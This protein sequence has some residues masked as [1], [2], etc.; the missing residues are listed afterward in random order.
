MTDLAQQARQTLTLMDLTSLN[1]SDTDAVITQLCDAART[2][3]GSPAAVC[4]YPAFI[5][6]AR[7]ALAQ[8]GLT[9]VRVATVTNFPDGSTNIDRAVRETR[10]AVAAG[11]H[12]VDVVLPYRAL[13]AGDSDTPAELVRACKAAC[14]NA[15]QLK[16]IIE[17]GELKSADLIRQ[18]SDI[19]IAAGADFIKTSTGK[20]AVNA[21]LEAADIM[22]NAIADSGKDVG[23]KA[24]GGIR[25]TAEAAQ[26]LALAERI[27]GA[28]W[29]TPEHFRFGASSLL[30]DVLATL[31]GTAPSTSSSG[32]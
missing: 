17:S 14:G 18:A 7:K 4:V 3:F 1:D 5:A 30:N 20:V 28:D 16:V 8:S 12:E 13:M 27:F 23:F 15:V 22:L 29:I 19:S 31:N 21:T 2:D 6:T 9:V 24:A 32:Y 25:T 11:A 26:Y 10:D